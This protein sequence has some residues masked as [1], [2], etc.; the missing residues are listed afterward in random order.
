MKKILFLF[1]IFLA[2]LTATQA[3]VKTP[4][5]P[6]SASYKVN[7]TIKGFKGGVVTLLLF[8]D[9][10]LHIDT[11]KP[12]EKGNF[13]TSIPIKFS[14]CDLILRFVSNRKFIYL[15][16]K[17]G[18][19]TTV[20][21]DFTNEKAPSYSF[22]GDGKSVCEYDLKYYKYFNFMFSTMQKQRAIAALN[23]KQYCARVDSQYEECASL[24]SK[25]KIREDY[26]VKKT[27]LD[28]ARTRA[29][30]EFTTGHSDCSTNEEF[31]AF[32]RSINLNDFEN[33]KMGTTSLAIHYLMGLEKQDTTLCGTIQILNAIVSKIKN[34]QVINDLS[35]RI[36]KGYMADPDK[37][38]DAIYSRFKAINT[39]KAD[40][41]L[42]AQKYADTKVVKPGSMAPDFTVTDVNGR[43]IHLTDLRGK[44]LYI[45]VW[46]TWCGPCKHETPYMAR[47]AEAFKGNSKLQCISIS[48]DEEA[49]DWKGQIEKEK[50][51]WSQYIAKGGFKSDVCTEYK[52][53]GIPRFM[54][55]G[56]DG[57]VITA[58]AERPSSKDII[59]YINKYLNKQ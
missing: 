36:V 5:T 13:A 41:A 19:S 27:E 10:Y 22:E 29:K 39:N 21:A 14:P 17:R 59:D 57:K 38:A 20:H 3:A 30:F 42:I 55:I 1:L 37:N 34:P 58:N 43:T 16:A 35:T 51:S 2:S 47:L 48:I 33:E 56:S 18:Y 50:P 52:I 28:A 24:L 49:K 7:G 9:D 40:L 45:D 54:L 6:V 4:K 15:F 26:L 8:R 53:V 32:V 23:F 31:K 46:A 12:D 25:V 44:M 11:I